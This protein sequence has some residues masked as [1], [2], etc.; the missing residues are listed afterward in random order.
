MMPDNDQPAL[1]IVHVP[2][3]GR[4]LHDADDHTFSQCS[5]CNDEHP[6]T[7]APSPSTVDEATARFFRALFGDEYDGSEEWDEHHD[8]L[9]VLL[10]AV[11]REERLEAERQYAWTRQVAAVDASTIEHATA[12]ATAAEAALA[13]ALTRAEQAEARV[14]GLEEAARGLLNA[15]HVLDIREDG[16]GV[17]HP[18]RCRPALTQ[19]VVHRE[20]DV[21]CANGPPRPIGLYLVSDEG[22]IQDEYAGVDPA[23]ALIAALAAAPGD[24]TGA[25]ND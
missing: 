17:Q 1:C 18:L 25:A 16:W 4:C 8:A 23:L 11:R 12:R 13:S 5:M 9:N 21:L 22:Y 10:A 20:M 19:C 3:A 15:P 6:F 14:Q 2:D 7:A 24:A